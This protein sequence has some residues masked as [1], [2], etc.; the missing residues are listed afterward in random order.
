ME[1][2]NENFAVAIEKLRQQDSQT[3]DVSVG[4]ARYDGGGTLHD[5]IEAAD[6]MMYRNKS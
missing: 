1:K 2:L 6:A 5:A 4:Y 3:P